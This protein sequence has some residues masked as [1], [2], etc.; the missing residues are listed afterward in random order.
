MNIIEFVTES[1]RI[2]GI[3]RPP[4][5]AEV[6]ATQGFIARNDPTIDPLIEL[7]DVYTQGKGLLRNQKGMDVREGSHVAPKGGPRIYS[8]LVALLAT[9]ADADPF[10][11]HVAYET[12]HPF[13]DGNGRTGRALWAWQVWRQDAACLDLGFLHSWYYASLAASRLDRAS[14]SR[15]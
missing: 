5:D 4:T 15:P 3:L 10:E 8:D 9:I 6:K 11:F 13:L 12:L 2:E 14:G 7:A 1:N